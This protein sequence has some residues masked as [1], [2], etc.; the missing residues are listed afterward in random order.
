MLRPTKRTQIP[1]EHVVARL[2]CGR[3]IEQITRELRH[4]HNL[5][6]SSTLVRAVA[7]DAGWPFNPRTPQPPAAASR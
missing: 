1:A 4:T 2:R 7:R 5:T 3:T 6:V